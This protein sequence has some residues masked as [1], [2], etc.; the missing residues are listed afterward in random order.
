MDRYGSRGRNSRDRRPGDRPLPGPAH[1]RQLRRDHGP[2][3]DGA[4]HRSGAHGARLA[5]A[6]RVHPAVER[7]AGPGTRDRA[8]A[9]GALLRADLS[10]AP[11]QPQPERGEGRRLRCRPRRPAAGAQ[12]AARR[13]L[14]VHSRRPARRRPQQAPP[15][16]RGGPGRGCLRQAGDDRGEDGRYLPRC[17][18]SSRHPRA[19][20]RRPAAGAR[21]GPQGAGAPPDRGLAAPDRPAGDGPSR[22]QPRGPARPPGRRARPG[23]HR[24]PPHRQGRAGDR[25]GWLHRLR[26]VPADRQVRPGPPHHAGP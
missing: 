22:H 3:A 13:P 12:H 18:C 20:A 8:D 15:Q 7:P 16:D 24:R 5:D 9:G 17:R 1:A 10:L 6:G 4:D 2:D 11:D 23:D 19:A 14:G 21:A 25:G 26:A